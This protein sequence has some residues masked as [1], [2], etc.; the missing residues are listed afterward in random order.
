MEIPEVTCPPKA[1]QGKTVWAAPEPSTPLLWDVLH[2][3]ACRFRYRRAS[4]LISQNVPVSD[5][6]LPHKIVIFLL[7]SLIE[8]LSWLFCGGVDLLKLINKCTVSDIFENSLLALQAPTIA[9]LNVGQCKTFVRALS[10]L[11]ISR[12][13][14]APQNRRLN[15]LSSNSKHSVDDLWGRWLSITHQ[16][17]HSAR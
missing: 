17:I 5:S 3:P 9:D 11:I 4:E 10:L 15:L 2:C 1:C 16:W 13:S 8:I 12:K 6:Q 14:T 7:Q